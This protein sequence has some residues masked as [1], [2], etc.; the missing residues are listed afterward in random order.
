VRLRRWCSG[1]CTRVRCSGCRATA[2]RHSGRLPPRARAI[3]ASSRRVRGGGR[4]G[5]VELAPRAT[6][7]HGRHKA[8]APPSLPS[9]AAAARR[10]LAHCF[11]A[12]LRSR[13]TAMRALL[14]RREVPAA[15]LMRA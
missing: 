14:P 5:R 3:A 6:S 7:A 4:R 9:T 12:R 1:G 15:P 10:L 11:A 13:T 2:R 8:C